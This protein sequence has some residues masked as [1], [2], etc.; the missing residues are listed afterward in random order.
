V[1][2]G[3]FTLTGSTNYITVVDIVNALSNSTGFYNSGEQGVGCENWPMAVGYSASQ[4]NA[5][6]FVLP[7]ITGCPAAAIFPV[8]EFVS[9][10]NVTYVARPQP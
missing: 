5:S 6:D 7:A 1:I 2:P 4:V 3:Y 8:A 10:M 9:G